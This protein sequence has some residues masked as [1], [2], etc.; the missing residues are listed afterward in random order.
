MECINL[1]QQDYVTLMMSNVKKPSNVKFDD[2]AKNAIRGVLF[3]G[4]SSK[5]CK[6][7]PALLR[8]ME[9]ISAFKKIEKSF[10]SKN[11]IWK[12]FVKNSDLSEDSVNKILVN[13]TMLRKYLE[14]KSIIKTLTNG[15]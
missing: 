5:V 3:N 7:Q 6:T 4:Y 12:E 9:E 1:H 13:K 15:F 10:F 14:N 11:G 2:I 8:T